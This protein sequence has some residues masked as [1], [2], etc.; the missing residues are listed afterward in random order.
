MNFVQN[1]VVV[2]IVVVVATVSQQTATT[3]RRTRKGN[4]DQSGTLFQYA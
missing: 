1:V 3:L 4:L 2:G